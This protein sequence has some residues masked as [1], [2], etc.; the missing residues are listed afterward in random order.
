MSIYREFMLPSRLAAGMVRYLAI[1]G[2][3]W[4]IGLAR[5]RA[6]FSGRMRARLDALFP[7]LRAALRVVAWR[8]NANSASVAIQPAWP[9]MRSPPVPQSKPPSERQVGDKSSAK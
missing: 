5:G 2:R 3:V 4:F 1:D 9:C 6:S 7:H 8:E